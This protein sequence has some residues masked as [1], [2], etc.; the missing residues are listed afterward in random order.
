MLD[1][2]L[3]SDIETEPVQDGHNNAAAEEEEASDA[4]EN[5]VLAEHDEHADEDQPAEADIS[6]VLAEAEVDDF[7][8]S[9]TETL[10]KM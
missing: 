4:L 2:K 1:P 6:Q 9:T 7:E 3:W 5:V 10:R 8:D